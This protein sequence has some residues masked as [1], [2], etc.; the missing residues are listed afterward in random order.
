MWGWTQNEVSTQIEFALSQKRAPWGGNA[1]ADSGRP[2]SRWEGSCISEALPYGSWIRD[3]WSGSWR[4][5]VGFAETWGSWLKAIAAT[6][7]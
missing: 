6:A 3:W 4:A 1:L 5:G 2:Q 7:G